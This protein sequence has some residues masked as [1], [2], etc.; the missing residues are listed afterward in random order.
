MTAIRQ[1][2]EYKEI[3]DKLEQYVLDR[4]GR[5]PK[6]TALEGIVIKHF[7]EHSH[8]SHMHHDQ[9]NTGGVGASRGPGDGDGAQGGG[10]GGGG[11]G[12]WEGGVGGG[13]GGGGGGEQE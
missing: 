5:H 10:G 8:L 1:R 9:L 4:S 11:K 12:G 13:G 3:I 6:L 7:Q 2:P